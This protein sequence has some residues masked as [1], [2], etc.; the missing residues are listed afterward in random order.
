MFL[1]ALY[2]LV[3]FS[4]TEVYGALAQLLAISDQI[5]WLTWYVF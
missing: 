1:H 3:F 4:T 2:H 5:F